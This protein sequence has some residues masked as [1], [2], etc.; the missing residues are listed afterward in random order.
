MAIA[1]FNFNNVISTFDDLQTQ[2][3]LNNHFFFIDILFFDIA[4]EFILLPDAL[5]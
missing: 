1:K 5:L 3:L 2:S 4:I